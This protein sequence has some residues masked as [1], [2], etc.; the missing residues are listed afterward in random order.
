MR[1]PGSDAAPE[2]LPLRAPVGG[3]GSRVAIRG[4][5]KASRRDRAANLIA[6]A[7]LR[8]LIEGVARWHGVLVLTYHRVGDADGQPWDR[9]LWSASVAE[10][11]GQLAAAARCADV[12]APDEFTEV[13]RSGRGR[14]LLI[15]FDDGY[16][17]NYEIAFPLLRRHGLKA[18]FFLTTGF[19][20][21]PHIGWW[22]E[23][24]WMVRGA[25]GDS[26]PGDR[27]GDPPLSLL[28]R[29]AAIAEIV[30]RYKSLPAPDAE[31]LLEW[32][33]QATGRGRCAAS[34]AEGMW[35]T[36]DMAREM[37]AAGMG[38][39]GH[40][41][42]HPLLS[43]ITPEQQREEITGCARR[44]REEVGIEMGMFAY[45]VGS[46]D[47]FDDATREILG[48]CG[49]QSA[50]SFYGGLARPARWDPLDVPRNHVGRGYTPELLEAATAL[51]QLFARP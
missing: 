50:F 49:V 37:H 39:G 6:R 15:T 46:P 23:I 29:E 44:L 35:M 40:T 22:D 30:R 24:A 42:S 2:V 4:T 13:M 51:P 28:D 18:I 47:A 1:G 14:H 38:I 8:P 48:E 41:V 43:R 7:H 12:I 19:L 17:D 11:D 26:I 5:P 32:L 21:R 36:W 16:R 10:L 20:D 34:E 31:R 45:P 25:P 33:G 3:T 27:P 9:G